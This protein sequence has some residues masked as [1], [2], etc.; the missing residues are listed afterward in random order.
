[1]A[2]CVAMVGG[3]LG[4]FMG[5]VHRQAIEK[6]GNLTITCGAF[7]STRQSS[8]D[9]QDVLEF[10]TGY[11]ITEVCANARSCAPGRLI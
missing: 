3:G 9:C 1:M 11:Q 6:A 2:Q 10:I 4:S 5:K 8:F 7:G